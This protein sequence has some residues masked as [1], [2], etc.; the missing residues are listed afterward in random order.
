M[1]K[2]G[3]SGNPKGKS[4]PG[5]AGRPADWYK[6]KCAEIIEKNK[7]M[8]WLG[9]V[10]RGED[11]EQRVNENGEILK[12]PASVKDRMR[13]LEML[14]DRAWG[15]PSQDISHSGSIEVASAETVNLIRQAIK[16]FDASR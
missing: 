15:K 13:A 10:A 2:K 11:V 14:Q 6:A 12:I 1:F 8:E 7:L 9:Q 16:E 3:Q 5:L 4:N